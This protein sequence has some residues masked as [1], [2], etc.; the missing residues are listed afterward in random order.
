MVSSLPIRQIL[1]EKA[2]AKLAWTFKHTK[3]VQNYIEKT[4]NKDTIEEDQVQKYLIKEYAF[5]EIHPSL[6][7]N[8]TSQNQSLFF[9][10]V[11][12]D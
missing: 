12:Y 11:Y 5:D 10:V 2:N 8:L 9:K 1:L 6:Q 7:N 4:Q 3:D